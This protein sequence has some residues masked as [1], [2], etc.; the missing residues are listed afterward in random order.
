MACLEREF[1]PYL[2]NVDG[3]HCTIR[4]RDG[5]AVEPTFY[6]LQHIKCMAF[7]G[8]ALAVEV[9]PS[10]SELVDGENQRHLVEHE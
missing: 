9:F 7:G 1:G 8:P 10:A 6:E 3:N 2:I 5:S 4:R